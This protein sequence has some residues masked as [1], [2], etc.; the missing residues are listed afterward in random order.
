MSA[1]K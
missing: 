1:K